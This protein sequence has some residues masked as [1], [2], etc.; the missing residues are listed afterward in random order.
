MLGTAED[1]HSNPLKIA[2]VEVQ[3]R[4][5]ALRLDQ[6]GAHRLLRDRRRVGAD[7]ARHRRRAAARAHPRARR[8]RP[9]R[10]RVP[11]PLH[12]RR[13]ARE[14]R[15]RQRAV[16]HAGARSAT[17]PKSTRCTRRTSCGGTVQTQP[18]VAT[19]TTGAD[20]CLFGD[21]VMPDGMPVSAGVHAARRARARLHAEWAARHHRHPGRDHPA[22]SRTR[23]ASPRATSKIELPIPWTDSWGVEHETVT[24]NPVA[25]HA[26]RGLA[27][28]LR[29]LPH[30]SGAGDPDVA[31]RHHRPAGRLPPQGA[32]SARDVRRRPSRRIA[33]RRQPGKPLVGLALGWP[34]SPDDLFVDADGG[35]VR[36]DK[37]FSLGVPAGRP[38]ADA[39][40]D[41]QRVA[42]RPVPHRHAA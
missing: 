14:L 30:Q 13:P 17:A 38:R 42:R 40:R 21:Y 4:R 18:P 35:P 12:Q 23:W 37:G 33:G 34:A 28:A 6:P 16:R 19:H 36:I 9:V 31:P 15:P 41:H 22:R 7:Q 26:M 10:P 25:F 20:P 24:G 32:V 2:I 5:R 27:G 11:R 1:H 8:H 39:Q 29:R 3:A